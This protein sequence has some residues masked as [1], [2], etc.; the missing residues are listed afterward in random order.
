MAYCVPD[1]RCKAVDQ[2]LICVFHH[3]LLD[4]TVAEFHLIAACTIKCG[5]TT[6][7][8]FFDTSCKIIQKT[9]EE[10]SLC[11]DKCKLIRLLRE[12]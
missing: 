11:T 3:I 7:L 9:C 12:I 8:R 2:E 4:Y 6:S 1:Y 10:H 5:L